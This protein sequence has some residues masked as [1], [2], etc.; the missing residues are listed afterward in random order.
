MV[1][2]IRACAVTLT[3]VAM[4]T[5]AAAPADARRISERTIKKECRAAN[6]GTYST[7]VVKDG[8]G[9]NNQ[10]SSCTYHDGTNWYTDYYMNGEYYNT[11]DC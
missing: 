8:V 7:E 1:W 6:N 5:A 2:T 11:V 3:A 9:V 4:V 10:F